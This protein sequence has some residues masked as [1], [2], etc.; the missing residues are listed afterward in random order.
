MPAGGAKPQEQVLLAR[1]ASRVMARAGNCCRTSLR[2][3]LYE[4]LADQL[5]DIV[6]DAVLTVKKPDEPIDLFMVRPACA[7]GAP[8]EQQLMGRGPAVTT[9]LVG[10]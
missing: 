9:G 4:G 1:P 10:R 8:L 5:T 7:A 2:T 3:K 6:V